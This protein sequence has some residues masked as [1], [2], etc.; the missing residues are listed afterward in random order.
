MS[1]QNADL[2]QDSTQR[3]DVRIVLRS[4]LERYRLYIYIC[5]EIAQIFV[6]TV[7]NESVLG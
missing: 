1:G 4:V 5:Q 6:R 3:I 7:H 2:C